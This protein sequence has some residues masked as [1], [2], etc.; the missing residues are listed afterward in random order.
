MAMQPSTVLT[1]VILRLWGNLTLTE[2]HVKKVQQ[3]GHLSDLVQAIEFSS[4][5]YLD[6]VLMHQIPLRSVKV[7]LDGKC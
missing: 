5:K 7:F 4:L 2:S 6:V 1:R 3:E